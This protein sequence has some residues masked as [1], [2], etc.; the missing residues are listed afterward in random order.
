MK[1]ISEIQDEILP[2]RKQPKFTQNKEEIVIAISSLALGGAEMIVTDWL[3][4][5][6]VKYKTHLIV[7]RNKEEEW[8]VPS[9]VKVTRIENLKQVKNVG[10]HINRI[11]HLQ[12]I[13]KKYSDKGGTNITCHLLNQEERLAL[14]G[15][16]NFIISVL[17]NA[18]VGWNEAPTKMTDVDFFVCV[19]DACA[20]DLKKSGI[21]KPFVVIKIFLIQ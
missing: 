1:N 3:S 16:N 13:G 21:D 20:K 5:M 18:K 10:N 4:R 8:N 12:K 9:F 6:S 11:I 15:K 19:S 17:H 7:L 14:K 2:E